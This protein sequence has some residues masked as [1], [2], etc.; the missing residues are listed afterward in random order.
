MASP[1]GTLGF[2][3]SVNHVVFVVDDLIIDSSQ[4]TAL[5]LSKEAFD[6]I[7][8]EDSGSQWWGYVFGNEIRVWFQYED[9]DEESQ[10]P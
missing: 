2:D 4:P 5:C 10:F 8:G 9:F 7:C 1:T 3:L 6:W